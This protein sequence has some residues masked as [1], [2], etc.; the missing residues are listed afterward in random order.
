MV[1][2]DRSGLGSELLSFSVTILCPWSCLLTRPLQLMPRMYDMLIST[3]GEPEGM[4]GT[5]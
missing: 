5:F 3:N 1:G 2:V 4:S